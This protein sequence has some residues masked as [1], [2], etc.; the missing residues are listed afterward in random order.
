[1]KIAYIGA[2]LILLSGCVETQQPSFAVQQLN[3]ACQAGDTQACANVA[4]LEA[5]DRAARAQMVANIQANN[6]ALM[7]S[8]SALF[9]NTMR[10]PTQTNCRPNGFGGFICNTY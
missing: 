5:Q 9:S 7:Q 3:A 8:N 6:N 10:T 1:M 2:T 4:N